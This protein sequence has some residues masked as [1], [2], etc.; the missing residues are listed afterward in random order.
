[1]YFEQQCRAGNDG[2]DDLCNTGG[3]PRLGHV[4]SVAICHQLAHISYKSDPQW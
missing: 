1:V 3:K 2:H 4:P